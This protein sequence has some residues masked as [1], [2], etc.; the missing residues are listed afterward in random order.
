RSAGGGGG[1]RAPW[2]PVW[3]WGAAGRGRVNGDWMS[4]RLLRGNGTWR[5]LAAHLTGGQGVAGSNPAVPTIGCRSEGVSD[6]DPGSLFDLRE[7]DG[8][9]PSLVLVGDAWCWA[10]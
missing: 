7:P 5:S 8:E 10:K 6:L 3:A 1:A 2:D 4:C 9:P